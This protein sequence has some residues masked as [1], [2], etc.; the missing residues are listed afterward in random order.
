MT[1]QNNIAQFITAWDADGTGYFKIGRVQ[2]NET[3]DAKKL[4]AEAKRAARDI[5]AEVMYAWELGSPKSNA[6]WLGWGGY[7]LEEDIPFFAAMT[8]A[9]VQEKIKGFDPKDNE[10]ECDS[11]DEYKEILF[12]AYDEELTADELTRGFEDWFK[13]L[14]DAA[15]KTLLKDLETWQRHSEEK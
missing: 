5:E 8:K 3:K 15:Q 7:D 1:R 2:L 12:N 13:T 14:D 11:L 9:E 10:F 4:E 6:W